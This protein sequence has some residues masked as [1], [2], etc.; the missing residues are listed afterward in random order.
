MPT[1]I[2]VL[3]ADDHRLFAEALE[4]ILAGDARISVVGRAGDGREAVEL[5][6]ELRPD[7]VL[8]DVSMPVL[9]GIDAT[10]EIRAAGSDVCVLMLTGSNSRTDVDRSREAGA[11]GY[12]TK[13]RIASELV[14]AILEVARR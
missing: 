2:R 11:S 12:V 10:R 1:P 9:D 8:M 6:E 4:A 14:D 13:D 3:I 5:A 7:V